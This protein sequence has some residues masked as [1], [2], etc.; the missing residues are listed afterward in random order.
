MTKI[1]IVYSE[2]SAAKFF[3]KKAYGELFANAQSQ[4]IQSGNTFDLLSESDLKDSAKLLAYK[5]IVFPSMANVLAADLPAIETALK[6]ASTAGVKLIA[7]G[8]FLTNSE[9]GAAIGGDPYVRMAGLLGVRRVAGGATI[10]AN[11]VEQGSNTLVSYTDNTS[12]NTYNAV[13]PG[14]VLATQT[15]NTGVSNAVI[16][17]A[18][19]THFADGRI[20]ADSGLVQKALSADN[21]I[22][23]KMTRGSSLFVSRQDVDISG[24]ATF[25]P[26]VET[27]VGNILADWKTKYNFVGSNYINAEANGT[28][29][30][31]AIMKPI[32]EKWLNLGNE[33]S[34][35]SKSHPEN[36]NALEPSSLAAEFK[37]HAEL[38]R[39]QLGVKANGIATPGNPENLLVDQALSSYV[40]E[41]YVSGVGGSS[42]T[43]S[44][45]FIEPTTSGAVFFKP[46]ISFDFNLVEFKKLT[47]AQAEA[48]WTAEYNQLKAT[49]STPIIE[50][51]WHDYA[52]TA[53]Q[54]ATPGTTLDGSVNPGYNLA[55]FENFVARAAKDGTEFVTASAL[56]DRFRTAEQSSVTASVDKNTGLITATVEPGNGSLGQFSFDVSSQMLYTG[57]KIASVTGSFAYDDNSVFT[58]AKGG[59]YQIKLG[60]S[61]TDITHITKLDQRQELLTATGDQAT[62]ALSFSLKGAGKIEI[63]GKD[64]EFWQK[65]KITGA[66]TQ[67]IVGDK[68]TLGFT[69]EP[70]PLDQKEPGSGSGYSASVSV[71]DVAPLFKGNDRN[72][73]INGSRNSDYI[74]G[75]KGN[76]TI[77]GNAGD[78]VIIGNGGNDRLFGG[79]GSDILLG[80]DSTA[81]GLNERDTLSGGSSSDTFILGDKSGAYYALDG[82]NGFARIT[83][84]SSEDKLVLY[85]KASDYTLTASGTL[86][87]NN[88]NKSN[89]Q[90][91]TGLISTA[92][93]QATF[94]QN[95]GPL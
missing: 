39:T 87:F 27:A 66:D 69:K 54:G 64:L 90:I 44:F 28:S 68:I 49:T 45:G 19:G 57:L 94:L 42:Y 46:N 85:G 58:T 40:P 43:N 21:I 50:F 34:T 92:L 38:L 15:N 17:T 75:L 82:L 33:I 80:T 52:L 83:D 88:G 25:A 51:A 9:T 89:D 72:N 8:D 71:V 95:P 77:Y 24:S 47:T 3:D 31:W 13:D 67:T 61:V 12:Y 63:E 86:L 79:T 6:T 20:F 36:I 59:T 29:P 55:M 23:L 48:Q 73:T 26:I 10:G 11:T 74:Q 14:S 7:S 4:A 81:K 53:D 76:D 41:G 18:K 84:F 16:Q 32:Y 37:T 2:T 91:A 60:A 30:D 22:D 5:A 62:G 70:S 65:Y 35:H 56:N 78:D 93:S 1:A